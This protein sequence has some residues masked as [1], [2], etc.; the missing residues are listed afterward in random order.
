MGASLPDAGSVTPAVA[1]GLRTLR[2]FLAST[3]AIGDTIGGPMI[4]DADSDGGAV[5]AADV[6]WCRSVRCRRSRRFSWRWLFV[7]VDIAVTSSALRPTAH[8]SAA[9]VR[10]PGT[11]RYPD[12][13]PGIGGRLP[14][15][16]SSSEAARRRR[17]IPR[18]QRAGTVGWVGACPIRPSSS[19]R[20][21]RA[22]AVSAIAAP[23]PRTCIRF[24]CRR[25]AAS[26]SCASCGPR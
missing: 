1:S 25:M 18:A 10:F 8:R 13:P 26:A 2:H 15:H 17:Q 16:G 23:I 14:A 20:K 3:P 9:T 7:W 19:G 12:V 22:T 4:L 6:S 11:R 5:G 24:A 21:V